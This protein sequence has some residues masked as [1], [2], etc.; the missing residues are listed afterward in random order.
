MILLATALTAAVALI[1]SFIFSTTVALL[2]T[3]GMALVFAVAW[4][5]VPLWVREQPHREPPPD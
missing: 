1:S 3:G 2:L 5:V 4:F